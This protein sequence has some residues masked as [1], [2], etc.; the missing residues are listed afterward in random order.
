MASLYPPAVRERWGAEIS[1]QVSESGIRSWPDTLLGAA[2][3]WLRPGDWPETSDGQT[4]QVL[5]VTL[6]AVTAAT[7]LLVRAAGQP[8]L[9]GSLRHPATSLWLAPILLGAALA[10]PAPPP[11]WRALRRLAAVAART[12][13]GPAIAVTAML[14]T[15]HAGL[16]HHPAGHARIGLL[17]GYWAVLSFTA[18]RLCTLI[19]RYARTA[20]LP[21]TRRLRASATLT[22]A[23]L[24]L[25]AAQ[26]LIPLIRAAPGT[27]S[28]TLALALALSVLAAATITAAHDLRT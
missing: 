5:T 4:R 11:R 16:L 14:A 2:R 3:L 12:L 8:V 17:A 26:S 19:A 6:F 28:L 9:T 24:S 23:G 20:H 25:A 13:A 7:A 15:A 10:A 1:R 27:G 22:G 18:Q 21:T